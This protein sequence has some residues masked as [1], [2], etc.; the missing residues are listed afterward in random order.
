M[1]CPLMNSYQ[2]KLVPFGDTRITAFKGMQELTKHS[3]LRLP[4]SVI[5]RQTHKNTDGQTVARQS[6]RY[7]FAPASQ[8]TQK[9][10][11]KLG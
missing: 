11:L 4:R 7:R 3:D 5:T 6:N 9:W 10:A 2:L 1:H 8:A